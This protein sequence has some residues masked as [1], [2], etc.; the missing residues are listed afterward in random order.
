[1]ELMPVL[2]S[3]SFVVDT[4]PYIAALRDLR[5]ELRQWR[6]SGKQR[7]SGG[8][9]RIL[10][11]GTPVG[12]GSHKV[13]ALLEESGAVAVCLDN[14]SGIKGLSDPVDDSGDLTGN[15]ARR[16]LDI[17]CACMT[18]NPGRLRTLRSHLEDFRADGIVD[19]TW[20]GCHAFN[21][22]SRRIAEDAEALGVPFLQIETGY[23]E[24]DAEQIR[25]RIEAF[26]EGLTQ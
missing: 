22:E 9:P 23:S 18:P 12:K 21:V 4:E 19:L 20:Q 10:L 26:L 5:D 24:S 6:D 13:L 25:T 7:I 2:E 16:Y 17:P 11:T 14:C 3:K 1:M 15:I 8:R